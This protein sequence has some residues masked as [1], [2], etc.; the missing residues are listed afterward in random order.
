MIIVQISDL[1][2]TSVPIF[3][4]DKLT[5]AISEINELRPDLAVVAGDLTEN[6]LYAL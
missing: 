1:H 5:A 2:C 6:G 3:L 4:S